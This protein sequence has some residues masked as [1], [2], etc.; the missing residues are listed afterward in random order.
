MRRN[1]RVS[2][3]KVHGKGL[4]AT[5]SIPRGGFIGFYGGTAVSKRVYYKN[6]RKDLKTT[7][8]AMQNGNYVMLPQKGDLLLFVNEPPPGR[9]ANVIMVVVEY[10]DRQAI[11]YYACRRIHS[12]EELWVHYGDAYF[13]RPYAVGAPGASLQTSDLED[14]RIHAPLHERAFVPV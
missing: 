10:E 1:L 8:N 13:E 4:F 12:G 11:A 7:V 14:P 9:N 5:K 3:S 6:A 2:P